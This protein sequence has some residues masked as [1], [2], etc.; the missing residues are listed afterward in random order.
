MSQTYHFADGTSIIQ[1]NPL[2]ERLW[3]QVNKDLSNLSN[4]LR[5][6]E[7]STWRKQNLLSLD[8]E[9]KKNLNYFKL[10]G[11]RLVPT[12]S[13]KYV[14]V[15]T[16]Q[17]LLWNKQVAQIKIRLNRAIGMLSKLRINTNFNILKTVYHS[18]FQSQL[19]YGT[20]LWG[21]KNNETITTFRKPQNRA[22]RK[23][24]FKKRHDRISRV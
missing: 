21:Q 12:H 11:K 10:D 22:L 7:V 13:V 18:L 16:D 23:V 3:K 19:H 6:N 20:Q 17:H 1:S 2:L 24:T 8:L 14:G 9:N 4:W 15:L 5:T